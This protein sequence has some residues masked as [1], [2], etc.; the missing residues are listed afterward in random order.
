MG[1]GKQEQLSLGFDARVR[2]ELRGSNITADAGLLAYRE[3]DEK[4]ELTAMASQFVTEQRRGRSIQQE[5]CHWSDSL[6]TAAWQDTR[7]PMMLTAWPQTR[8]WAWL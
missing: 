6:S 2:L 5:L 7:T 8:R 4:L 1:E 3:L